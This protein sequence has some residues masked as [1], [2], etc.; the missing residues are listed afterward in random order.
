MNCKS[1]LVVEDDEDIRKSV[2]KA[3]TA[4]G[5]TVLSATNGNEA[6]KVLLGTATDELPGCM[7][8]DLM[9]P[10]MD[11]RTL[12]KTIKEKHQETLGKIHVIVATAKGSVESPESIPG[13]LVRIQKPFDLDELYQIVEKYCGSPSGL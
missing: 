10:E 7:I 4:E 8:L 9:M 11:G 3:L 5:Y 1:I 13:A 2:V 12:L 6:L